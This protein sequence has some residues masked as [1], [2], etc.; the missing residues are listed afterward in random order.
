VTRIDDV[1]LY[2]NEAKNTAIALAKARIFNE[3]NEQK[4]KS[5]WIGYFVPTP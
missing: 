5:K 3:V 2:I 1:I 4:S